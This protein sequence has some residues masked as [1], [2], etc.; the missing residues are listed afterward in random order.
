MATARFLQEKERGG[1]VFLARS[2]I[3]HLARAIPRAFTRV[4]TNQKH[5]GNQAQAEWS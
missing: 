1:I 5:C 2:L 3:L 4:Q